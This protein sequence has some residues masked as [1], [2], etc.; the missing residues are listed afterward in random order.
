[1]QN[2]K[3]IKNSSGTTIKKKLLLNSVSIIVIS[4]MVLGIVSAW[5]NYSSTVSS[6]EH[7]MTETVE[8]AAVTVTNKIEGYKR[9]VEEMAY[10]EVLLSDT[11]SV[12]MKSAECE[13]MAERNKLN[14]VAIT[15]SEGLTLKGTRSMAD[16]LFFSQPK[17][18]GETFVSNLIVDQ[19]ADTLNIY[20]STP[21]L[22][23]GKF[24]GVLYIGI[25]AS[26]LCDMVDSIDI[27]ET[28]N[29][30]IINS[31]GET[32]GYSDRQ[33]VKDKYNTQNEVAND[34]QLK[35][36][37]AIER[38]V[39]SGETGFGS[40][41]YGGVSKYVAFAPITGTP[42]WGI[43]VAVEKNEFLM[44]TYVGILI[45]IVLMLVS[46]AIGIV[47]IARS[48]N[49][50]V[51][52][53]QSCVKR[54]KLLAEGDIHTE[55]PHIA[56]GDETQILADSMGILVSNMKNVIGDID[57]C[58][59]ELS[60]GDFTVASGAGQ[61]YVGDFSNIL[62]SINQLKDTLN[63]TLKNIKDASDQVSIG[64]EQ[65]SQNAQSLAEGATEQA[66][67]VEE[68][69]AAIF[70]VT[71]LSQT[72]SQAAEKAHVS[73]EKATIEAG[74]S[75]ED[76]ENLR[77]AMERISSTSKDIEKIIEEIED[78]ASQTNLLSLNASI[79]AA[80]AGEAGRGFA[81]VAEQI[82]K[83]ASDS[84][85]SAVNTR[86]MIVKSL[87]EI[88]KGSAI[89]IKATE[90]FELIIDNMKSFGQI[91][92]EVSDTSQAQAKSLQEIEQGVEDISNVIQSNSA[93]AQET[94]A[95]SEELSAQ[96]ITLNSLVGRF[97][98]E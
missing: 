49:G 28:G 44:S 43:Y 15:D 40:Y 56:T 20:I 82:G 66:G 46:L 24:N 76:M 64:A 91:V 2:R 31:S 87:E 1:M 68:L 71:E 47:L 33:L 7:T 61:S 90:A 23:D 54:I 4:M 95:T 97:K 89:T 34:P 69:S 80:R 12:E 18:N 11:A 81:V 59:K 63:S 6:L 88:E 67:A 55:V 77:N 84:A 42:G 62:K 38:R 14:M 25:D 73:V 36:L 21:V 65:L 30:S 50:I 17:Q 51:H 74:R 26:L 79:E 37:A 13:N 58:L 75:S 78:I 10:N 22:K 27:G 52:P 35:Q 19:E 8:Q 45:V 9:L 5:M 32:I 16:Y 86:E 98:C 94:S 92:N 96:S 57:Y 41:T 83:L 72:S 29:A 53:I 48:A 39:M 60:E 3:G 70:N 93:S 85:Q